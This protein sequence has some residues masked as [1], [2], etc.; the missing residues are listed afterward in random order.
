MNNANQRDQ[1]N[2]RCTR[3]SMRLMAA[4]VLASTSR[5]AAQEEFSIEWNTIDCGGGQSNGDEFDLVATIAQPDAGVMWGPEVGEEFSISGG[6]WA[7]SAGVCY[8]N[9]DGSTGSPLLT[10]NDFQCFLNRF[11]A[12]NPYANCDGSTGE[13]LLTAN[14]FQCFLNAFAAGCP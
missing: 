5:A 6:F 7:L 8:A 13:P 1:G 3:L 12:G 14:D 11:A 2:C 4:A 9:C 10:S